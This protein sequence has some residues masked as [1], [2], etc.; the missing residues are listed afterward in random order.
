MRFLAVFPHRQLYGLFSS[1]CLFCGELFGDDA[2]PVAPTP[3]TPPVAIAIPAPPSPTASPVDSGTV[4]LPWPAFR[5]I[6]AAQQSPMPPPEPARVTVD[7]LRYDL[8]VDENGAVGTFSLSGRAWSPTA[9]TPRPPFALFDR[10]V[11]VL[12]VTH[13]EG[14]AVLTTPAGYEFWPQAEGFAVQLRLAVAPQGHASLAWQSPTAVQTE[15]QLT[16]PAT[17]RFTP[18]AG[19]VAQAAATVDQDAHQQQQ[20]FF[21]P[22][23][24]VLR[25]DVGPPTALAVLPP[26]V[27]TFTQVTRLPSGYQLQAFFA[28]QRPLTTTLRIHLPG[29]Q[30]VAT[31][32][33]ANQWQVDSDVL[34]ISTAADANRAATGFSLTY[35]VADGP[36]SLPRIAD[37]RGREGEFQLL[38]PTDGTLTVADTATVRRQQ[39]VQQL[40]P[41]LRDAAQAVGQYDRLLDGAPLTLTYTAF[42]AEP[43]PP[44]VLPVVEWLTQFAENGQQLSLL[45]LAVPP[46]LGDWLAV[47]PPADADLWSLAVNGARQT[48]YR[49]DNRWLIRLPSGSSAPVAVELAYVQRH[50]RLGLRGEL[51][52][53]VPA[54]NLAAERLRLGVALDGSRTIVALEGDVTPLSGVS[55]TATSVISSP[56]FLF[57]QPFYRG[58]AVTARLYYQEPLEE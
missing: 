50:A 8:A 18:P 56:N 16:W 20:Q 46:S 25:L 37:N 23:S 54:M 45:R 52:L 36:L 35:T 31:S 57:E 40:A 21:L 14:G 12:A 24:A 51:E 27:D 15:L 3:E 30:V 4:T 26:H 53:T 55:L 2:K 22:P 32:L 17:W 9:A 43:A 58:D 34:V 19:A 49:Q 47:T 28:P 42:V 6:Y 38:P 41:A 10:A 7:A 44:V 11:T 1:G 39:P 33:A 5:D 48:L 29:A 13:V